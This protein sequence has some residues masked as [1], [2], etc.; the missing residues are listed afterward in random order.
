MPSAGL[1]NICHEEGIPLIVDEAHG[2]HLGLL[3]EFPASAIQQG[4]DIVVQSTHK[5]LSSLGQ[6]SMLHCQGKLASP[7]RLSQ[8]LR[9]LQVR[10][11][12]VNL[13]TFLVL[14]MYFS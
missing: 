9:M 6:S 13:T 12:I 8:C 3:P 2:S 7:Q 14:F 10:C 1:A 4:A 11:H 5:T